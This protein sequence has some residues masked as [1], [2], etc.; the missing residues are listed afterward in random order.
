MADPWFAS[1]WA[2]LRMLG[3]S[4]N[5]TNPDNMAEWQG[6]ALN[7]TSRS[8]HSLLRGNDGTTETTL[9]TLSNGVL[10]V[11]GQ[12]SATSPFLQDANGAIVVTPSPYMPEPTF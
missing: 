7:A 5:G 1:K 12:W 9:R 4:H 3:R 2:A 6:A 11:V 10:R 8:L